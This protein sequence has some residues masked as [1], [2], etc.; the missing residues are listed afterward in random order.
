[1]IYSVVS[2]EQFD[3]PGRGKVFVVESP[4]EVDRA[5]PG[6]TLGNRIVIDGV[7]RQVLGFERHMLATP[8]RAGERIGV[9]V[10]EP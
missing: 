7:E 9:L 6:N 3:M 8:I 5:V 10:A 1:M 4:V 2:L